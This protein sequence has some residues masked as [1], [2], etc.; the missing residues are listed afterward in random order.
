[1]FRFAL[2]L[3]GEAYKD[4]RALFDTFTYYQQ[5]AGGFEKDTY[6]DE[7]YIVPFLVP[8]SKQTV[9]VVPGGGFAYK[10]TDYDGEGNG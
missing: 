7:P 2:A 8:G 1:M 5:I 10:Q 3:T 9:L 4:R 6:E